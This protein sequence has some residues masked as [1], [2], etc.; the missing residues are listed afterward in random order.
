[1]ASLTQHSDKDENQTP[2]ERWESGSPKSLLDGVPIALKDNFCY[3]GSLPITCAS[4]HLRNHHSPYTS[5]PVLRL[6]NAGAVIL[7][8]TN[9]DEFAMGSASVHSA[10]GK[11]VNPIG[12]GADSDL[13]V[14]EPKVA[15]GSSGGSAAA[16]ASGMCYAALG[17]DTGGSVRLP[18]SYCGIV[19]FKPSYGRISRWGLVSYSSSLDTVGIM[20]R[21]VGCVAAVYDLIKG[22]DVLDMT[23]W[24]GDVGSVSG[25][26]RHPELR[27]PDDLTGIVVG[28]PEEYLPTELSLPSLS[29]ISAALTHLTL[30]GATIVPVSLPHTRHALSAYYIIAPAEA[31]SNLAR[32]DGVR[33]GD[34]QRKDQDGGTWYAE[35]RT[36]G[37]GEEVR[38][39]V[40]LGT[41][42]LTESS[43]HSYFLHSQRFRRLV[44]LDFD[45]VFRLPNPLHGP[46]HAPCTHSTKVDVLLTPASL[47]PAPA[48]SSYPPTD[49]VSEYVNDVATIPASLAGLPAC[50]VPFGKVGKGGGEWAGMPIGVQVLGQYMDEETV[51]RVASVVEKGG[52]VDV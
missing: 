1:M 14:S 10:F 47:G 3:R 21:T 13:T 12:V 50:V 29:T 24:D 37:F 35:T 43:Y 38:R 22:G 5:T 23:S 27:D 8:K 26:T 11:V 49:P 17:S 41:F 7:G 46:W 15:G 33:Y 4:S 16:V 42:V 18:A 32:Y 45:R 52:V 34:R 6:L 51:L 48:L 36:A 31:S 30:H 44:Q 20:A 19:G 28:V 25:R 39:R 2:A 40:L 9:M